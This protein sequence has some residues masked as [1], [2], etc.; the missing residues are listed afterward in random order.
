LLRERLPDKDPETLR[1]AIDWY[2]LAPT[3]DSRYVEYAFS[4]YVSW[5]NSKDYHDHAITFVRQYK[6][7]FEAD[8]LLRK[9]VQALLHKQIM[10]FI[11]KKKFD[12][13]EQV[14]DESR[15]ILPRDLNQMLAEN[16]LGKAMQDAKRKKQYGALLNLTSRLTAN[17]HLPKARSEDYIT[18]LHSQHKQAVAR[19]K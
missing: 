2:I 14:L 6:K 5:L 18:Y 12:L 3:E 4:N 19:R 7:R 16:L 9:S 15:G 13:A 11:K 10:V 17:G 1:L 8:D